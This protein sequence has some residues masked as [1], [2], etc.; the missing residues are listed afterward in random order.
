VPHPAFEEFDKNPQ[1]AV[2]G[3]AV[4]RRCLVQELG[5]GGRERTKRGLIKTNYRSRGGRRDQHPSPAMP[6][7]RSPEALGRMGS[8]AS[9]NCKRTESRCLSE[10]N[11]E[12]RCLRGGSSPLLRATVLGCVREI[13]ARPSEQR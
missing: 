7:A 5:A 12:E 6:K 8:L 11:P 13:S 9:A 1:A 3:L 4:L 10:V 2:V